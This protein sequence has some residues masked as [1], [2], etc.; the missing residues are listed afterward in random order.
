MN[1][2]IKIVE[3]KNR[4]SVE[5]DYEQIICGNT[6]YYFSF[7]FD[8]EWAV[9]E[10]K[11]LIIEIVGQRVILD[12][13]ENNICKL[14]ALPNA[15]F[16]KVM[17]KCFNGEEVYASNVLEIKLEP[18]SM[19]EDFEFSEPFVGYYSKLVSSVDAIANGNLSVKNSE[20]SLISGRSETQVSLTGDEDISGIKNFTNE[21]NKNSKPIP[22][23]SEVIG[24][25]LLI[26]PE[27][28]IN[29]RKKTSYSG[30]KIYMADRW[31]LDSSLVLA[32]KQDSEKWKIS[33]TES[34]TS[35]AN[36]ISQT[37]ENFESLKGKNVT[38]SLSVS[39][40][41][42]SFLASPVFYISDGVSTSTVSLDQDFV[43]VS[44][45]VS[46]NATKLVVGIK[47]NYTSGVFDFIFNWCK[48]EIGSYPTAF[49]P[50]IYSQ[51]FADCQRYFQN[52]RLNGGASS[53][54]TTSAL[55]CAIPLPV[56]MRTTPTIV[57]Y[58]VPS[59]RG[60]GAMFNA[61]SISMNSIY[62]N[63]VVFNCYGGG[64]LVQYNVYALHNGDA[65]LDAEIY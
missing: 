12:I 54:S 31:R 32:E 19:N 39:S 38:A 27:M 4:I 25:N 28:K 49:S 17:V 20:Y 2:L 41:N 63:L 36:V 11:Q 18:N 9:A 16:C 22:N 53:A 13:D 3:F 7:T 15:Y 30:S 58:V 35:I 62:D 23:I 37:I 21:I 5:E 14:P 33:L 6:N 34:T 10:K 42:R 40:L 50:K 59:I 43:S 56:T 44:H 65:V 8:E 24:V 64:N 57:S 45:T 29:Q 48:L 26:N 46:E 47:T 55:Y 52:V 60:A 61:T 1:N 51:D